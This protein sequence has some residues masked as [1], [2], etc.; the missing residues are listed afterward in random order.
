[1]KNFKGPKFLR[2]NHKGKLKTLSQDKEQQLDKF[3]QKADYILNKNKKE[4]NYPWDGVNKNEKK[5]LPLY[6][7]KDVYAKLKYLSDHTEVPQ[8]KIIRRILV[9]E[10]EKRVDELLNDE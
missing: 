9:P 10:V 3:A 4:K 5:N 7:P 2:S 8:Q 6:L 1:M